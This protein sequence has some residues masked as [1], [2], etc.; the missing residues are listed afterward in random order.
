[1]AYMFTKVEEFIKD[2]NLEEISPLYM[3]FKDSLLL[4]AEDLNCYLIYRED[5]FANMINAFSFYESASKSKSD[6]EEYVILK[7]SSYSENDFY[8]DLISKSLEEYKVKTKE[9]NTSKNS[10]LKN[11]RKMD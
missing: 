11:I 8:A 1:M 6:C 2:L 9:F 10:Y 4:S 5:A 3:S 7:N